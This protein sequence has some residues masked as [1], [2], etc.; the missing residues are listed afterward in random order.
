MWNKYWKLQVTRIKKNGT[1]EFQKLFE[2]K[3][4]YLCIGFGKEML[5]REPSIRLIGRLRS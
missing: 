1:D 3:L 5:L 4:K 2:K